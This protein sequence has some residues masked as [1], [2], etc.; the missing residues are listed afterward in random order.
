M[1]DKIAIVSNEVPIICDK[2]KQSGFKLIYTDSVDEF[3]PYE[4]KHADI[5]CLVCDNQIFVLQ[6]STTL[7]NSLKNAGFNI[8]YTRKKAKGKYPNN[9]AL[10]A[11]VLGK[12]IIGKLDSLDSNL[13]SFVKE[14]NYKLIN[15]KQGYTA[16]SCC[17]ISENAVIT[18]DISIYNALLST[19]I[20]ILKIRE[21]FINLH[22][23]KRGEHGFIGGAS[24]KIDDKTVLF[25]GNIEKHPDYIHIKHFCKTHNVEIVDI[26]EIELTDIGGAVL[27]NI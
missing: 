27:L 7:S 15:V 11:V 2:L 14:N 3:I 8:I 24:A 20:D 22:G 25:F 1:N 5:Q 6:N 10:N 17:K 16:C 9:I 18:A 12:I 21:G 19:E 13:L 23:S 26:K 4:K